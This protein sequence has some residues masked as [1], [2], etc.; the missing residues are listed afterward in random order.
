M[1]VMC[2]PAAEEDGIAPTIFREIAGSGALV[3]QTEAPM[4]RAGRWIG[5]EGFA[6]GVSRD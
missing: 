4:L 2:T 5:A 6:G 3:A 1:F